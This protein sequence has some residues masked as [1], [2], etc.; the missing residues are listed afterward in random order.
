MDF[1]LGEA[2][3]FNKS[4][5]TLTPSDSPTFFSDEGTA[6]A[7]SSS[8]PFRVAS[9]NLLPQMTGQDMD[10]VRSST[11]FS[12]NIITFLPYRRKLERRRQVNDKAQKL[13][14]HKFL[15]KE[16]TRKKRKTNRNHFQWKSMSKKFAVNVGRRTIKPSD[17][18]SGELALCTESEFDDQ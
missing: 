2:S 13:Y 15:C 12:V 5:V 9:L 6:P 4:T 16:F 7:T 3:A 17:S 10:G 18:S 8:R 14:C 11:A 1:E